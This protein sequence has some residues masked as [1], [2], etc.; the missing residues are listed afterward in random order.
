MRRKILKTRSRGIVLSAK[1]ET[2][3]TSDFLLIRSKNNDFYESQ[4][5]LCVAKLSR[6]M[7]LVW[8]IFL[9]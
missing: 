1:L 4:Y 9:V 2:N 8:K 5:A 6:S 7:E 3:F